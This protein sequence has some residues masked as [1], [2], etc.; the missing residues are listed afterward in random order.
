[1][2]NVCFEAGNDKISQKLVGQS[3]KLVEQT[4]WD[5]FWLLNMG[6][7]VTHASSVH[8]SLCERNCSL[9][10]HFPRDPIRV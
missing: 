8:M 1:M 3:T 5:V 10:N 7:M 9:C 4:Q 2:E 6:N